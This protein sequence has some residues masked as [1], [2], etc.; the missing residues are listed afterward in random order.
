M[1]PKTPKERR[2]HQVKVLFSD[3]EYRQLIAQCQASG[4][5]PGTYCRLKALEQ[6]NQIISIPEDIKRLEGQ[7]GHL[8]G[9]LNQIAHHLNLGN[10]MDNVDATSLQAKVKQLHGLIIATQTLI[11]SA[12]RR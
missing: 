5:K 3:E 7:L 1:K 2:T 6:H 8:G 12:I 11:R 4:R 10:V 9:N